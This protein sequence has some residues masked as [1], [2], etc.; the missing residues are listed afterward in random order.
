MFQ[1]LQDF[2]EASGPRVPSGPG[3]GLGLWRVYI[4]L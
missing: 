2:V 3:F 4:G 1:R